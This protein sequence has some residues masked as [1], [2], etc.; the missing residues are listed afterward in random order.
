[1][2]LTLSGPYSGDVPKDWY[3]K[4]GALLQDPAA[5]LFRDVRGL[6]VRNVRVQWDTPHPW[7]PV[8]VENGHRLYFDAVHE[9]GTPPD[10]P[11]ARIRLRGCDEVT[12]R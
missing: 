4:Y 10:A 2:T 8:S 11:Q 9:S 3:R 1:V 6:S 5:L 12:S 7:P